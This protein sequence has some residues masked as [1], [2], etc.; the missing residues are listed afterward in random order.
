MDTPTNRY[1]L[2]NKEVREEYRQAVPLKRPGK[3]ED[4][5]GIAVFLASDES[6]YCTGGTY[7]RD[8]GL[9]ASEE[10]RTSPMKDPIDEAR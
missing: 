1:I 4:I 6:A 8:N 10:N 9:T 3:P 5:E 2:N 7:M